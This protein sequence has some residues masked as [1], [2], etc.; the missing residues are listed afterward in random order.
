MAKKTERVDDD[1]L[2][3]RRTLNSQNFEEDKM[4]DEALLSLHKVLAEKQVKRDC[5]NRMNLSEEEQDSDSALSPVVITESPGPVGMLKGLFQPNLTGENADIGSESVPCMSELTANTMYGS[6]MQQVCNQMSRLDTQG[7]VRYLKQTPC[8]SLEQ[9]ETL[10]KQRGINGA[11]IVPMSTSTGV[12]NTKHGNEDIMDQ[13][14]ALTA[15]NL[16]SS[17][18]DKKRKKT[19]DGS[20][21]SE[22]NS[23]P[24]C[25]NALPPS[26]QSTPTAEADLLYPVFWKKASDANNQKDVKDK[27]EGKKNKKRRT[28]EAPTDADDTSVAA[29]NSED[30]LHLSQ[31]NLQVLDIRT[32]VNLYDKVRDVLKEHK[33]QQGQEI[34]GLKRDIEDKMVKMKAELRREVEADTQKAMDEYEERIKSLEQ[35]L[36]QEKQK[37]HIVSDIVQLN[38]QVISDLSRRLDSV[39]MAN[40]RRA[41]ILSGLRFSDKKADRNQQIE[42][43]FE[44]A[45]EVY[46]SVDDSYFLGTAELRPVV[47]IFETTKDKQR[48]FSNKNSLA[49]ITGEGGRS[50]YLNSYLPADINEKKR[51]ERDIIKQAKKDNPKVEIEKGPLG[52]KIGNH[53]YKKRVAAPDPTQILQ[54]T[55]EELDDILT[56]DTIK[57]IPIQVKDSVFTPYSADVKDVQSVRDVYLKI[58]LMHARARHVV[59]VYNLPGKPDYI[60]QDFQDDGETGAGR[61]ILN[62]MLANDIHHKV[63]VV[64]RICGKA[65]LNQ[66]RL[67]A[68]VNAAFNVMQTNS[69]NTILKDHQ[70]ALHPTATF[71]K[72]RR[73]QRD[74]IEDGR[75]HQKTT[76]AK[77]TQY[78]VGTPSVRGK[79]IAPGGLNDRRYN[80]HKSKS[81]SYSGAVK[82]KNISRQQGSADCENRRSESDYEDDLS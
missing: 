5:T 39:E 14:E 71:E 35:S 78:Q 18:S 4:E 72:K 65:K 53:P 51:R 47:I 62:Y 75:Q 80:N 34:S 42:T 41:G 49:N 6:G 32:V 64:A 30:L 44:E 12:K 7:D 77:K 16:T 11:L 52:I 15:I 69:Y 38:Y 46:I 21:Q 60:H 27:R 24:C 57:G 33:V 79:R 3:Q 26:A 31:E 19:S 55:G 76:D 45:L 81:T 56:K 28:K 36:K 59:C 50:I 23:P 70:P 73:G 20:C 2:P 43:F 37:H 67:Q 17:L 8:Q 54:L 74:N 25:E 22:K 63:I 58:R 1:N 10:N 66:E 13:S 40:A 29:A 48:A 68:Y 82:Y 61:A 9:T